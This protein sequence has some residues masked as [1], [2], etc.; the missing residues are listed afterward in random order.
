MLRCFALMGESPRSSSTISVEDL[1]QQTNARVHLK[2]RVQITRSGDFLKGCM[3]GDRSKSFGLCYVIR[4]MSDGLT[5][6]LL[7]PGH[8]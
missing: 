4:V 1:N 7:L 3:V 5:V 8:F 6:L 2:R